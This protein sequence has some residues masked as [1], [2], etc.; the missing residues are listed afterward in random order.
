MERIE[1]L[2]AKLNEQFSR[3]AD[4]AQLLATVQQLQNELAQL[5][6]KTPRTLGTSKVAVMM[7]SGIN[8]VPAE[9]ERYLPKTQ[10]KEETPKE[11]V[12]E[13]PKPVL[14]AQDSVSTVNDEGQLDMAFDPLID[15]PTLAHQLHDIN[16]VNENFHAAQ[17]ESL[18]DK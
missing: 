7:P 13:A 2:I 4:T 14:V 5:Q 17:A 1:S 11:E 12:K 6:P 15:I 9:Y 10:P 16:G 3:G 18:N 8:N